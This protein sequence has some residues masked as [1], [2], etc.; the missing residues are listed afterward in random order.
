MGF[1]KILSR[2]SSIFTGG[3]YFFEMKFF[4]W[5]NQPGKIILAASQFFGYQAQ[6]LKPLPD[7]LCLWVGSNLE[8]VTEKYQSK[9]FEKSQSN[10]SEPYFSSL[11]ILGKEVAGTVTLK[12]IY[13]IAKIKKQDSSMKNVPMES[14]CK[15]IIG[16]TKSM[17]IEV[18]PG[19]D[20]DT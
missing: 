3:Q 1:T 8:H 5:S 11:Y 7:V 17:G 6:S 16:S 9:S 2:R 10:S 14:L 13:E 19:R 18:V 12:Q 4:R 20:E 15:V